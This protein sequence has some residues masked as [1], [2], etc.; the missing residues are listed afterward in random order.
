[1]SAISHPNV[2][3][4]VSNGDEGGA[5]A[6]RARG[7]IVSVQSKKTMS[8]EATMAYVAL[9]KNKS[10]LQIQMFGLLEENVL[11]SNWRNEIARGCVEIFFVTKTTRGNRTRQAA[12]GRAERQ[13]SCRGRFAQAREAMTP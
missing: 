6:V 13:L 12:I 11:V 10:H 7:S 4:S 2:P 3:A 1:M 9:W 8:R 5:P